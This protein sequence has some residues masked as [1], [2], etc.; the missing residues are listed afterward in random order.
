MSKYLLALALL[1][2]VT[3][4][5]A[6]EDPSHTELRALLKGMETAIN[7]ER[8]GDL[9]QYFH[10]DMRVTTINQE[11]LSSPKEI[12]AYFARWFGPGGYLKKV[13]MTLTPDDLT[14]FYG[15]GSLGIVRGA[16]D[17]N[18]YLADERYFEMKTRWTA[19]V[20]KDSDNRWRILTLHIG[21]NFL[22]NPILDMAEQSLRKAGIAGGIAGLLLGVVIMFLVRRRKG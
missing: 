10:K 16:G 20:I 15:G 4:V 2:T 7:T 6:T 14:Q 12:D 8:Y 9:A 22:D 5:Q 17:E 11:V 3:G 19:T 13:E 18:Y 1:L 21:T